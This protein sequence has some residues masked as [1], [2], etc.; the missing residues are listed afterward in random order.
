MCDLLQ[1]C[2]S[3]ATIK[4]HLV[5]TLPPI[6]PHTEAK[7]KLLSQYIESWFGV[8]S[9]RRDS[10]TLLFVDGF[11][12]PDKYEGGE[13]G[14]P[15]IALRCAAKL[16]K[17]P[18]RV[19]F[20][21]IDR[22]EKTLEA[23][24]QNIARF[25]K[26]SH[27]KITVKKGDFSE[28]I[29]EVVDAKLLLGL[30]STPAFMFVDP[31]GWSQAGLPT[32]AKIF[33]LKSVEV[34]FNLMTDHI[35]RFA[36]NHPDPDVQAQFGRLLGDDGVKRV[37]DSLNR[38]EEIRTVFVQNMQRMARYVLP[39]TMVVRG[40][41]HND[42]IWSGNHVR[43]N[44][45]MKKVMYK[46]SDDVDFFHNNQSFTGRLAL[47]SDVL[48][49]AVWRDVLLPHLDKAGT[50]VAVS[51]LYTMVEE[52]PRYLEAHARRAL[53]V[54]EQQGEIAVNPIKADGTRRISGSFPP[55]T[56][57]QIRK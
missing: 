52:G 31:F 10:P 56:L 42:L 16:I 7:H 27:F 5:K 4:L 30:Q 50:E 29:A 15:T 19:E 36:T 14:S 35:N 37:S 20:V 51:E 32:M 8:M 28:I 53:I 40:R 46:V 54:A 21:F 55:T 49:S 17:P 47:D 43:G 13:S 45:I 41:K 9:N 1:H 25:R 26:L 34:L 24:E 2:G 48:A 39:F 12:G 6:E 38:A 23:L 3:S 11:C 22:D 57:V 18:Q 33:E 44:A